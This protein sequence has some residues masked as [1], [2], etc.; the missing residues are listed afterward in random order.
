MGKI[1]DYNA[2]M[3]PYLERMSIRPCRNGDW[4]YKL[5]LT[6]ENGLQVSLLMLFNDN[7]QYVPMKALHDMGGMHKRAAVER[8]RLF[9]NEKN[10]I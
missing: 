9:F 7:G 2:M 6:D 1:E 8:F 5:I 3:A 4:K 10:R